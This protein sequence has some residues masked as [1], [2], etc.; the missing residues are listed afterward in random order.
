MER[1]GVLAPLRGKT[2]ETLATQGITHPQDSI[3]RVIEPFYSIV[4]VLDVKRPSILPAITNLRRNGR[5][6]FPGCS[7]IHLNKWRP[8]G[9]ADKV[10]NTVEPSNVVPTING[11]R[12][13][14]LMVSDPAIF[15]SQGSRTH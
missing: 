2:T 1:E 15:H 12:C 5:H 4:R 7:K 10:V 14:N 9:M 6:T 11:R 3:F 13:F 8:H